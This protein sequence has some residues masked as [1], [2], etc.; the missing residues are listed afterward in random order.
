MTSFYAKSSL[1]HPATA[2][3]IVVALL[4]FGIV[5]G[6]A[7]IG[8]PL[9]GSNDD[10]GLAMMGAGFGLAAQPEP[11]LVFSHYG[12][13]LLLNVLSHIIGPVAHGWVTMAMLGSSIALFALALY[14]QSGNSERVIWIVLVVAGGCMFARALLAPD[15]TITAALF[16]GAAV[17]FRMAT[18][19]TKPSA[20]LATAIYGAL[21]LSFLVRPIVTL[22]GLIVVGPALAWF[23]WRGPLAG[24]RAIRLFMLMIAIIVPLLYLIDYAAYAFSPDW[25]DALAYNQVRGLFNDFNR[26]PWIPNSPEYRQVGWS[27]NDYYKSSYF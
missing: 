7:L 11:H 17:S 24:R 26:V 6:V 10:T 27:R 8:E 1:V 14:Q 16:F 25:R 13:G 5:I 15:F 20:G 21:V 22:L 12:Y 4:S 3:N 9:F 18:L 23:A 19:E 2:R